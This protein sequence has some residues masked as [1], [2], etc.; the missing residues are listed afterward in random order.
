M[1]MQQQL[2]QTR[3]FKKWAQEG[4]APTLVGLMMQLQQQQ[5]SGL[6][7]QLQV[8]LKQQLT[9]QRGKMTQLL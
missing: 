2:T 1:K 6:Q 8:V 9:H 4:L 5:L 3:G 7:S